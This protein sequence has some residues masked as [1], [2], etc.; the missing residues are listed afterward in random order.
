METIVAQMSVDQVIAAYTV[1]YS[2]RQIAAACRKWGPQL[3]TPSGVDGVRLFWAIAGCESSFGANCAPRHEPAY[4]TGQYSKSP[5][6]RAL[7]TQ[8]G[9]A[10]HCSFGPWQTLLVNV[11]RFG[12]GD[13]LLADDE[14]TPDDMI[15]CD[16]AARRA[17]D[18][19][20]QNIFRREHASTVAEIADA[21]NS[22]DWRDRIVP[23]QYI[24]D[25]QRYYNDQAM[26]LSAA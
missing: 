17:V 25:C 26:P 10:A 16:I 13:V 5:Q 24:A 2:Q 6:V 12:P 22:G 7:T 11:E 18:F 14:V 15:D 1:R 9:H 3:W 8:F 21:Y 20:N 19:M 23:Q 4:C